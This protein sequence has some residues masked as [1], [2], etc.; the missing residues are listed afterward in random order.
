VKPAVVQ[1]YALAATHVSHML[2]LCL[3]TNKH[4]SW[5]TSHLLSMERGTCCL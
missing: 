2:W 3:L 5:T 4:E 1:V